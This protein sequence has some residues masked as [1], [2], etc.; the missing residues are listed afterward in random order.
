MFCVVPYRTYRCL[1]RTR[2]FFQQAS[3]VYHTYHAYLVLERNV[4]GAVVLQRHGQHSLGKLRPEHPIIHPI[5]HAMGAAFK[6]A[7]WI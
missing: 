3:D 7:F 2:V 4:P 1:N 6:I 5:I